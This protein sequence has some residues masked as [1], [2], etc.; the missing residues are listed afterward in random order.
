[1]PKVA[2]SKVHM[3]EFQLTKFHMPKVLY[4]KIPITKIHWSQQ[5]EM[6]GDKGQRVNEKTEYWKTVFYATMQCKGEAI[7]M[8]RFKLC[9]V[10]LTI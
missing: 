1:M 6:W 7:L 2:L 9:L 8:L 3:L 4:A 10:F 5:N